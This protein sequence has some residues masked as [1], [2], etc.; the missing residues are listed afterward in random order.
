MAPRP[1]PGRP[2]KAGTPERSAASFVR[3]SAPPPPTTTTT[4]KGK[5]LDDVARRALLAL[6]SAPQ[7]LLDSCVG[8]AG[9]YE[10]QACMVSLATIS[11]R[12]PRMCVIACS[13]L[14]AESPASTA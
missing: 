2:E 3:G 6:V 7:I 11:G 9:V 10:G 8:G 14:A 4:T 13:T 5:G 12:I 1:K